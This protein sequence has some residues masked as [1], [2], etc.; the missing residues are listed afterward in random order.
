MSRREH[1]LWM[2][3]GPA[4]QML[5]LS[6]VPWQPHGDKPWPFPVPGGL[7]SD[8]AFPY[9]PLVAAVIRVILAATTMDGNGAVYFYGAKIKLLGI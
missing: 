5:M 7:T 2:Y 3:E 1:P 6:P 9:Q 8:N 4:A